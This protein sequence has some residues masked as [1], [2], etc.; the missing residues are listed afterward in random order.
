MEKAKRPLTLAD[1]KG[2]SRGLFYN[3]IPGWGRTTRLPLAPG[4]CEGKFAC[5]KG[6]SRTFLGSQ[7]ENPPSLAVP[8]RQGVSYLAPLLKRGGARNE[9]GVARM[10]SPLPGGTWKRA[11]LKRPRAK[12]QGP[13]AR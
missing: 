8:K 6:K 2:E 1:G 4:P 3:P 13:G 7:P 12:L 9:R 10:P 11:P 5:G